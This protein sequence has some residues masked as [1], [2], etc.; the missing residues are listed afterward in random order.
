MRFLTDLPPCLSLAPREE[1]QSQRLTGCNGPT[2]KL[3]PWLYALRRPSSS[4]TSGDRASA[5]TCQSH[6]CLFLPTAADIPSHA[7]FSST[8]LVEVPPSL[9][10]LCR[11]PPRPPRGNDFSAVLSDVIVAAYL[12]Q[13]H[14]TLPTVLDDVDGPATALPPPAALNDV[15]PPPYESSDGLALS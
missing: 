6:A 7:S 13:A 11:L 10:A 15:S 12:S 2:A 4:S 1:R 8:P 14:G 3:R 5:K 9:A